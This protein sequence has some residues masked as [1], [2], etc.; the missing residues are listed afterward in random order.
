MKEKIVQLSNTI[1]WDRYEDDKVCMARLRIVI[2]ELPFATRQ[3]CLRFDAGPE[4]DLS[5]FDMDRITVEYLGMR[6]VELSS[7]VQ[8]L[9]K[10]KCPPP[11]DFLVPKD[12]VS[13]LSRSSSP[14]TVEEKRCG[15]CLQTCQY[16]GDWY[17]DL[18]PQCADE[19]E[20]DG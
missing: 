16:S 2:T 15:R 9:T 1:W 12:V 8:S 13:M 18:C 10:A 5:I 4:L 6:G 7:E 19:T 3:V 11:C 20:P 14:Q 17:G